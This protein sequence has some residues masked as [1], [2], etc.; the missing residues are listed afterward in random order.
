M[1]SRMLA[2]TTSTIMTG[3]GAGGQELHHQRAAQGAHDHDALQAD[4]DDAGVLG[5][6][7]AQGHQQQHGGEDQRVLQQQQHYASPPF[8]AAARP[9]RF[10]ARRSSQAFMDTLKNSTKPHR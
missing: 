3:G 9:G 7:A 8:S 2:R 4:V 6:A 5:E 10:S 1:P